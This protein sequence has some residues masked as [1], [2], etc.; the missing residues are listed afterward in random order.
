MQVRILS[1]SAFTSETPSDAVAV[2]AVSD[3]RS[4]R[5]RGDGWGPIL[6]LRFF[7]SEYGP[8]DVREAG[9]SG[10]REQGLFVPEMGISI[11]RFIGCD[12][13]RE[14]DSLI[15]HFDGPQGCALAVGLY[16]AE[17]L[18]CALGSTALGEKNSTVY[19]LLRNPKAFEK[20]EVKPA[21]TWLGNAMEWALRALRGTR[22]P[23]AL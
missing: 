15:V 3:P 6:N 14:C 20:V 21:S 10:L 1:A 18:G 19:T 11:R 12:V 7:D 13:V 23:R 4:P 17:L 9:W 8:E 2:I 16:V 5:S 22:A